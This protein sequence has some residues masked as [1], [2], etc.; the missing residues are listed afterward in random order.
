MFTC[1]SGTPLRRATL[2]GHWRAAV[3][4]TGAPAGLHLH[5]LR[6]HAATIVAR[7]P[8]VTTKEL[9]AR[10]GHSSPRAALIYQHA[11]AERDQAIAAYLGEQMAGAER[12]QRAPAV[13]LDTSI[14][15]IRVCHGC[16]IRLGLALV[17]GGPH[18][19]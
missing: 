5:D 13:P 16:A 19:L 9:M 2:S 14:G 6:H 8:G 15:H 11:T 17:G 10:I 4:A 3:A 18:P 1:P 12:P 7:M